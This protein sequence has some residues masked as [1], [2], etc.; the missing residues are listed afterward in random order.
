MARQQV[1][2]GRLWLDAVTFA[3]ALDLIESLAR[4]GRVASVFTPNVDHLVRAERSEDFRRAHEEAS[5]SLADGQP[6]VWAS[7]LLGTP[8]PEKISG[9]DL[10][11]PLLDRIARAKMRVFLLGGSPGVGEKAAAALRQRGVE[12]AGLD[13]RPVDLAAPPDDDLLGRLRDARPNVVLVAFGAPKQEIWIHRH[14][15]R[16]PSAVYIGVGGS[17]DFLAGQIPRA[18]RWMSRAGLEWLFRLSREP[19]RLARRYLVDDVGFLGILIRTA[20]SPRS[21][22]IR[23]RA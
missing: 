14:R 13:S 5:L 8:L 10:L 6:V 12:V 15:D 16:L 19:R 4:S 17:L 11:D 7:R 21:E 2:V 20:R 23:L 3:E 1:R 9:S 22:R 18:P